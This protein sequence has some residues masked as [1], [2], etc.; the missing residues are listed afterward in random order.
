MHDEVQVASPCIRHCCLD[1]DDVCVGC[2]RTLSE[3]LDWSYCNSKER[4]QI[5]ARCKQRKIKGNRNTNC[6]GKQ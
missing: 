4:Q 1:G 2:Y 6:G 5:L 3:I